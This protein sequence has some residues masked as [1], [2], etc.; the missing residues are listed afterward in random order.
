MQPLDQEIQWLLKEKYQGR[1][2]PSAKE[3]IKRLKKGEPLA[4]LI[5]NVPFLNCVIDLSARPL[6]PRSE[7]EYWTEFAIKSIKKH[8]PQARCLDIFAGSGC[9]GIAILKNVPEVQVDFA[10]IDKRFLRQTRLNLKLNKIQAIRYRLIQSDIFKNISQAKK[11]DYILANPPYIAQRKKHLTQRSVLQYEPHKALFADKD[12][13]KIIK[14]FLK[15]VKNYLTKDGKIYMEFDSWQKENIKAI[16][17]MYKYKK[18]KFFKD[19]YD[20]WRFVV[21]SRNL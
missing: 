17:N 14:A 15:D 16:L 21:V 5:G 1:L 2:T 11:Y 6:I 8:N 4:Y 3:D 12:G 18:Y 20:K 19:Q 13:L 9:V 7:T 10:E